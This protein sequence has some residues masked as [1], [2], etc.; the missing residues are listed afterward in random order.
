MTRQRDKIP[1]FQ[2]DEEACS[3]GILMVMVAVASN[4]DGVT[5]A[6]LARQDTVL[7]ETVEL[8]R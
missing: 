8:N 5:M 1:K 7:Q 2:M 6:I 4:N 3:E